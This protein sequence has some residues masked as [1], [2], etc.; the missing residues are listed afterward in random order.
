M[1]YYL[2]MLNIKPSELSRL[3]GI[4]PSFASQIRTGYRMLPAKYCV[5]VSKE[6]GIPMAKLRPDLFADL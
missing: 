1:R 6:L 5:I 2:A 3:I 4:S